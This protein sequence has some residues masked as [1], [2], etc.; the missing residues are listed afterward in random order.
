MIVKQYIKD[1]ESLGLGMFVHF[2]LYSRLAQGEW[3]QRLLPVSIPD[4]EPL[5]QQFA[6]HPQW[7]E[8]LVRA[9]KDTGCKYI[10][11]TSRHHDGFSL[12]DTCGLSTYDAPHSC[13]R[14]LAR[15]FVDAC[16]AQGILPFFYHTLIDWHHPDYPQNWDAYLDYLLRSVELLCTNYG[17]LGGLWF[18]GFWE[19]PNADWKFDRF[20]AMIRSHQPEAV[21]INNTGLDARGALGH[22][23]LDS[24]TFERGK[25]SPINLDGSPKY[26]ASEMCEVLNDHWGCAKW[27][28]NYKAPAVLI[29]EIADCRRFGANM[30]LNVGPLADGLIAPLDSAYLELIGRWVS[31]HDEA[32]RKPLPTGIRVEPNERDF[33]LQD[34]DT[35]YLF[36]YDLPMQASHHVAPAGSTEYRRTFTFP[37]AIRSIVWMDNEEAVTYS[38]TAGQVT[39]QAEPFSYGRS[40]VVR[41]AKITC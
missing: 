18:D 8:K 28:L 22:P 21:L 40:L 9:A 4:Y 2:G 19:H 16:N 31:L 6:P 39:L 5:A 36:L 23:E 27:D 25:P 20:Y 24:V 32:I 14:D 38:Q 41:I 30:L 12:Y 34:G 7:A 3:A 10:T 13:G 11:L 15:E 1:F 26:I 29:E 33:L 37:R 35:Y 17:K